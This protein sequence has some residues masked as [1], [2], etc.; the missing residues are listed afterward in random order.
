MAWEVE[1]TDEFAGWWDG[2]I[3]S[4]QISISAHVF[5]SSNAAR[6]CRFRFRAA[7][8]DRGTLICGN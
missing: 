1:Y 6:S 5:K 4:E 7:Y 3:E 2:L 8:K